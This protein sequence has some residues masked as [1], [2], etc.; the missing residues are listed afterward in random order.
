MSLS[1]LLVFVYLPIIVL[2][3]L[4]LIIFIMLAL[5]GIKALDIYIENNKNTH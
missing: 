5:R 4:C 3:V 1:I 2:S